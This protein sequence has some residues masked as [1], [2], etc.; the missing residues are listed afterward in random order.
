MSFLNT[1]TKATASWTA[2]ELLALGRSYQNAAVLGAAADLD[3][4]SALA[5]G[6][7]PA[8]ALAQARACDLRGITLLLDALAALRL[9]VKAGDQY[10]LVPGTAEL[11][12]AESP[13]SIL[14]MTQH[15]AHCLRNWAQLGRVVQ[16]GRPADPLPSVR[17]ET[18]DQA[19]FIGG[20]HNISAPLCRLRHSSHPTR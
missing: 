16:S 4:F 2:D 18:G 19:A 20:M 17:G 11:L 14:A 1:E 10:S 12:T 7:Q 15:H 6:P 13:Q 9:L 8:Q 3:L 5:S